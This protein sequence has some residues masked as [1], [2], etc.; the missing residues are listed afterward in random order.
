MN[1]ETLI[2]SYPAFDIF[3]RDA[4]HEGFVHINDNDVLGLARKNHYDT[5]KT[6][7]VW[8]FAKENGMDPEEAAERARNNNNKLYWINK[9]ATSITAWKQDKVNLINVEVGMKVIYA[10][11]KFEI[12]ADWNKNLK[13]KEL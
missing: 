3:E 8:T 10:G 12:A 13:L 5:F 1:N 4:N 11:K 6:G 7:N 9:R 2:K